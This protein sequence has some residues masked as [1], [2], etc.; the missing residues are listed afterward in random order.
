MQSQDESTDMDTLK[1]IFQAGRSVQCTF[2]YDDTTTGTIYVSNSRMRGNF[3]TDG[4]EAH[5]IH[6]GE[7]TYSWSSAAPQGVKM[8]I[9]PD[10][11]S[12]EASDNYDAEDFNGYVDPNVKADYDC[13]S[14]NPDNSM[15]TP[16]TDITFIDASQTMEN[17]Q[18]YDSGNQ[19][20]LCDSV[21]AEAKSACK[22]QF[23]N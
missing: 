2:S 13:D 14:W 17:L 8:K 21:P 10:E 15:F 7:W 9:S 12:D 11:L 20:A 1:N 5:M 6:D 23:C 16:P 22:A 3:M 4:V 18:Q 19:C